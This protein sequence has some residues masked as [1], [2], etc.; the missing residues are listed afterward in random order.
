[1]INV[2]LIIAEVIISYLALV[3][4]FKK[5]KIDGIYIYC[6]IAIILSSIMNLKTISVM[7]VPIPLGFGVTTSILIGI[8]LIIQNRGKEEIKPCVLM[9]FIVLIISG[10]VLYL[11]SLMTNSE[12]NLLANMSYNGIFAKSLRIYIALTISLIITIII[13]SELFY[14]I[15][16]VQNKIILSNIFS[17]IIA[18][19]FENVIFVAIAYLFEYEVIDLFLCIILRYIIKTT[20]GII[21]TLPLYVAN[22]YN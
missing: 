12:F 16:K 2:I 18:E 22:K 6:I 7:N 4:L 1:M 5:Y 19:F 14:I 10:I 9:M 11:S 3:F 21:G 15:K 8:N 13:D 17:I 20:I